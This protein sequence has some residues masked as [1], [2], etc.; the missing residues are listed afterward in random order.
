MTTKIN[1]KDLDKVEL[2]KNLWENQVTAGYFTFSG[3]TTTEI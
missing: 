3:K 2:L 1:I